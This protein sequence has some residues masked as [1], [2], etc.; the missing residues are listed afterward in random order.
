[1]QPLSVPSSQPSSQP[2]V[3]YITT[4]TVKGFTLRQFLDNPQNG[5]AYL[6]AMAAASGVCPT[7]TCCVTVTEIAAT[8]ATKAFSQQT[9]V[10]TSSAVLSAH[11][12]SRQSVLAV[13]NEL[14]I[15]HTTNLEVLAS[16]DADARA[17]TV[18]TTNA[19]LTA[20]IDSGA[21]VASFKA[22]VASAG[23]TSSIASATIDVGAPRASAPTVA[24]GGQP[25]MSPIPWSA[26]PTNMPSPAPKAG[27]KFS[28]FSAVMTSEL[29]LYLIIPVFGL[30][31]LLIAVWLYSCLRA[32]REVAKVLPYKVSNHAPMHDP[33]GIDAAAQVA[34]AAEASDEREQGESA[35]THPRAKPS[36]QKSKRAAVAVAAAAPTPVNHTISL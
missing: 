26:M 30:L 2:I 4:T 12:A 21:F 6:V 9:R 7:C 3:S 11:P 32:R 24:A 34:Q 22:K 14:E 23:G 35:L 1:M 33:F 16:S 15:T 20:A 27:S 18:N 36:S 25:T 17:T 5:E 31:L 28:S 10:K 29:G 19:A 8:G 13:E